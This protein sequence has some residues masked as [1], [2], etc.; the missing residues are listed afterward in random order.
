[1][2]TDMSGAQERPEY[3]VSVIIVNYNGAHVLPRCLDAVSRAGG[4]LHMEAVVVDNGSTDG[5]LEMADERGGWVRT[6]RLGH[7]TGFATANNAGASEA[8]GR[9]LLLLNSDC[10]VRPGL[11]EALIRRLENES[12]CAVAGPRLLNPDGS[13]QPS[14]HN[15]PAPL[16]FFLEQS[17]LWRLMRRVPFL[18][19]RLDLA[20]PHDRVRRVDWLAGACLMVRP[21]AFRQVG[22]F[23]RAFFFYWE[24]ADL[25][26]RLRQHGW[27]TVFDPAAEAVHVGGGST[28]SPAILVQFFRSLYLFY[29]RHFSGRQMLEIRA[30]VRLMALFKAAR[31]Y[32][33]TRL[34]HQPADRRMATDGA[35]RAWLEVTR[36]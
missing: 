19:S 11:F 35:V 18:A 26:F 23:D 9:Y 33:A 32:L 7:N 1:M 5:S 10:F 8:R 13:T 29:A 15:F 34:S 2:A 14:C 16:V 28:S 30:I 22:G 17:M 25:C 31:G 20:S 27:S 6:I 36:L 3:D 4:A 12:R 21:E 24:E